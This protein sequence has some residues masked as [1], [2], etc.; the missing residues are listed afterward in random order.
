MTDTCQIQQV[1]QL[2]NRS[3]MFVHLSTRLSYCNAGKIYFQ[4]Q[5]GSLQIFNSYML[6]NAKS[7]KNHLP[8]KKMVEATKKYPE[9]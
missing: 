3:T 7:H 4:S 5:R 2:D 8:K 1:I 9:E 6:S